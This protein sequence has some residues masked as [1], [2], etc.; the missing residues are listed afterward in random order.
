MG[1]REK[2][3]SFHPHSRAQDPFRE[4]NKQTSLLKM[5]YGQELFPEPGVTESLLWAFRVKC[6][7]ADFQ[8]ILKSHVRDLEVTDC[9]LIPTHVQGMHFGNRGWPLNV[10]FFY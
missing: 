3:I 10:L 8:R 1:E 6:I 4:G 5:W 9:L 2:W 7:S